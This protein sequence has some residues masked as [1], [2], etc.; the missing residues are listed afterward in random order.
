MAL[1]EERKLIMSFLDK[2]LE[3]HSWGSSL[4][5]KTVV[6]GFGFVAV[7]WAEWPQSPMIPIDHSSS[8]L[9]VVESK[10]VQ[11]IQLELS[12]V[13]SISNNESLRTLQQRGNFQTVDVPSLVNLNASSRKELES[14]PGIGKVLA[15]RIVTYRS[16]YGV[17]QR[18]N[19]LV[20]VSG[21]G[22]KR[23]KRL[24]PFVKVE[25]IVEERK[26]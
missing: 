13:P 15:G 18:V 7:L 23:L 2:Y 26:S 10:A 9:E 11:E 1:R 24:A 22:K 6:L 25:A 8:P 17:F 16:T 12:P 14:L 20:K 5:L 3:I 4:L 19:D 21:I